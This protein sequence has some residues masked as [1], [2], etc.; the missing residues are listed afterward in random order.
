MPSSLA[1]CNPMKRCFENAQCSKEYHDFVDSE[2][3]PP[4]LCGSEHV[5]IMI[6]SF[7]TAVVLLS[8]LCMLH[9]VHVSII[10][11]VRGAV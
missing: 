6:T 10:E 5:Y 4:K 1:T 2:N 9:A 8:A 7:I 11:G 3:L